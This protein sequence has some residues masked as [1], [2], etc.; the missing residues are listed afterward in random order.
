[1]KRL[2]LVVL[3]LSM[4]AG[5]GMAQEL[6][7]GKYGIGVGYGNQYFLLNTW[8]PIIRMSGTST[9]WSGGTGMTSTMYV[10]V[11]SQPVEQAVATNIQFDVTWR[12]IENLGVR[13]GASYLLGGMSYKTNMTID[14]TTVDTTPGN[15]EITTRDVGSQVIDIKDKISGFPFAFS[16]VPCF[17]LGDRVL[18]QPEAGVAYYSMTLKGD[19][20][21]YSQDVTTT[22][23]DRD[24]NVPPNPTTTTSYRIS[25][26]AS[27]KSPDVK[28]SGL[29]SFWGFD[30]QVLVHKNVAVR[31][32]FRKGGATLK[33]KWDDVVNRD[34]FQGGMWHH[35]RDKTTYENSLHIATEAYNLG[36]VYNF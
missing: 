14:E 28:Y 22:T 33:E 18:L 3:A 35:E 6:N 7:F 8:S 9:Y 25:D 32:G 27:G 31:A 23:T 34:Y 17:K 10:N 2:G 21:T 19:K 16:L 29:G 12:P 36:L 24:L 11:G 1:M 15:H 26:A 20:G 30:T 13:A 4:L 5:T